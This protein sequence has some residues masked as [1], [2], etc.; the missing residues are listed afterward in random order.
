MLSSLWL[1]P[2]FKL[3]QFCI[4]QVSFFQSLWACFMTLLKT[5]VK[6][7]MSTIKVYSLYYLYL[8]RTLQPWN[9]ILK[10]TKKLQQV[11]FHITDDPSS[12]LS[13]NCFMLLISTHSN[14]KMGASYAQK[15]MPLWQNSKLWTRSYI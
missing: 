11:N 6:R 7:L 8:V 15:S 3:T 10:Q 14:V 5:L 1:N 9:Q 4:A 12:K 13:R 2:K